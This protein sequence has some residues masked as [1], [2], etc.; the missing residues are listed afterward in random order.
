M[1]PQVSTAG[2]ALRTPR[3]AAVAGIAFSL[4][5]GTSLVLIRLAVPGNIRDATGWEADPFRRSLIVIALALIPFAGI[6]FLWFLGVVRTR[7]GDR[8][9]R[10]L[11]SVL[12]GS[13]LLFVAMMFISSAL[14]GGLVAVVTDTSSLSDPQMTAI[15]QYGRQVTYAVMTTYAMRMAAV[16]IITTATI[17]L[18]IGI[19]PRWMAILGYLCAA[20]LLFSVGYVAWVELVF[21]AWVLLLSAYILIATLRNPNQGQT[22]KSPSRAA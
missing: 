1:A 5:A 18:K 11:A 6:A 4:L 16:F 21:P 20:I 19:M 22:L 13:G 8:E 7:I 9:D 15:W 12:L 17:S 14:A 3:A 10:F 2:A